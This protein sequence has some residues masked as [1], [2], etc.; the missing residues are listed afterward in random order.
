MSH[1]S[2]T[3]IGYIEM[4]MGIGDMLGPLIGAITYDRYGFLVAFIILG[5]LGGCGYLFCLIVIPNS[6][7][8]LTG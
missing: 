8:T 2:D 6:L 5:S 1:D 7:N 4:S 3:Y